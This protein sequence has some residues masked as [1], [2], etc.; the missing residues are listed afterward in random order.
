MKKRLL[1]VFAVLALSGCT[2][3][4]VVAD[5]ILIKTFEDEGIEE[6]TP[7]DLP[8]TELGAQVDAAI[9]AN[10]VEASGVSISRPDIRG[11]AP[12]K[13][14][15]G[16]CDRPLAE[17]EKCYSNEYYQQLRNSVETEVK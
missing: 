12:Q 17:N 14:F 13:S 1:I 2:A 3:V 9:I 15:Y 5:A 6:H 11:K 4:G 7:Q 8:L 16:K 10:I